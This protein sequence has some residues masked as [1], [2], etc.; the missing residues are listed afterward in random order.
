[1]GDASEVAGEALGVIHASG[2]VTSS[3]TAI[4]SCLSSE[5]GSVGGLVACPLSAQSC[6]WGDG[7]GATAAC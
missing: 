5:A 4:C 1:M 6:L 2:T 3:S 7:E